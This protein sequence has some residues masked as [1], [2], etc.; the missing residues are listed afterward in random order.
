MSKIS[1]ALLKIG[2]FGEGLAACAQAEDQEQLRVGAGI[3]ARY[4]ER[5]VT[6]FGPMVRQPFKFLLMVLSGGRWDPF[7]DLRPEAQE[8]IDRWYRPA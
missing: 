5:T 6:A 2:Q 8:F 1:D 3:A 7:E 4:L